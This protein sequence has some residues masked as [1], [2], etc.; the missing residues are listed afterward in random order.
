M[1]PNHDV[2]TLS[3][4]P[5]TAQVIADG[6]RMAANSGFSHGAVESTMYTVSWNT[7]NR[8]GMPGF[9]LLGAFGDCP[10]V[11]TMRIP[12]QPAPKGACQASRR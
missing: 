2:R 3:L 1:T 7:D 4:C 12:A 8:P 6:E 10:V 9:Q 11:G 5:Q